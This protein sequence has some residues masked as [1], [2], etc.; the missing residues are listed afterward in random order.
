MRWFSGGA[1]KK[2]KQD[3]DVSLDTDIQQL[4]N[5]IKIFYNE[6]HNYGLHDIQIDPFISDGI[7]KLNIS[8]VLKAIIVQIEKI[9]FQF[10][11]KKKKKLTSEYLKFLYNYFYEVVYYQ[12]LIMVND[13]KIKLDEINSKIERAREYYDLYS[14]NCIN[15]SLYNLKSSK[16]IENPFEIQQNAL[17]REYNDLINQEFIYKINDNKEATNIITALQQIQRMVLFYDPFTFG[18]ILE[19]Y[20]DLIN[21]LIIHRWADYIMLYDIPIEKTCN[22]I[23]EIRKIEFELCKEKF[24]NNGNILEPLTYFIPNY[25]E[26]INKITMSMCKSKQI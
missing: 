19:K 16:Q 25:D 11:N 10:L 26:L 12:L 3:V 7:S 18:K 8:N 21:Q 24:I 20:S 14:K 13:Y 23:H 17:I 2:N 5:E 22:I 9:K 4:F 1:P 6:F 15:T